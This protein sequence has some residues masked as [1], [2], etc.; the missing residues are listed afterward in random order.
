MAEKLGFDGQ[1]VVSLIKSGHLMPSHKLFPRLCDLLGFEMRKVME[2]AM[3]DSGKDVV[4]N[5]H[6]NLAPISMSEDQAV[7]LGAY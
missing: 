6:K 1:T 4:W 5:L 7:M 3:S 2:M